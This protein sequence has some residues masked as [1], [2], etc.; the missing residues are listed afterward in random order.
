MARGTERKMVV[1][2]RSDFGIVNAMRSIPREM[3]E[4]EAFGNL[5]YFVVPNGFHRQDALVWKARYPQLKVVAW[6]GDGRRQGRGSSLRRGAGE[7]WNCADAR[8]RAE[9]EIG[10]DDGQA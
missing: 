6:L 4:L 2:K 8:G 9:S 7:S 5:R 3:A 1:A 10:L